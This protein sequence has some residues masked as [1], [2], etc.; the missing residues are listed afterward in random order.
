MR[1]VRLAGL[2]LGIAAAAAV[3]LRAQATLRNGTWTGSS[4]SSDGGEEVPLSFEVKTSGDSLSIVVIV[5]EQGTLPFYGVRLINDSLTFSIQPAAREAVRRVND[6][7]QMTFEP[8]P[9]VNCVLRRQADGSFAGSC[10]VGDTGE[11]ATLRM[12]PPR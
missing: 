8:S 1:F 4:V 2:C 3:P 6:T 12:V 7:T 11:T 9:Q 5:P 10:A